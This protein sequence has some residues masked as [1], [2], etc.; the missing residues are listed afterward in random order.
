MTNCGFIVIKKDLKI[1]ELD[2]ISTTILLII[3]NYK[4][5]ITNAL[6]IAEEAPSF[7]L[8]ALSTSAGDL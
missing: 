7:L 2:K 5:R 6:I 4:S 1:S 8:F 3:A